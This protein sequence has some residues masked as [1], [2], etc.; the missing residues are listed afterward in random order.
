M[1]KVEGRGGVGFGLAWSR[2]GEFR[3]FGDISKMVSHMS[4]RV[5]TLS[6]KNMLLIFVDLK[7]FKETGSG[8]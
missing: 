7:C 2:V 4:K 1:A 3:P 6:T 8:L 5:N